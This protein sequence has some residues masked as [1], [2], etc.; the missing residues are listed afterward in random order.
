MWAG[1]HV[2]PIPASNPQLKR[3][4]K[5]LKETVEE[6][7]AQIKAEPAMGLTSCLG[8]EYLEAPPPEYQQQTK[9]S[10]TDETGLPGYKK[11]GEAEV[12]EGVELGYEYQTYCINAP[13]YC[14]NL[15]RKYILQGGKTLERDIRTEWEAFVLRPNVEFVINASGTGFR[16]LKCFPT[17]GNLY[18]LLIKGIP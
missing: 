17:R 12:P 7:G 11:L 10:F 9:Q 8:I 18:F 5:W 15:L 3:E 14:S 2:R 16:D 1:A 13:L 4:A 6:F